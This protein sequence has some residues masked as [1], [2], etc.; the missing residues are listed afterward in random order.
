MRALAL[1]LALGVSLPAAAQDRNVSESPASVRGVDL[2]QSGLALYRLEATP[3]EGRVVLDVPARDGDDVLASLVVRDAGGVV[4]LRTATPNGEAGRSELFAG[5]VPAG[6][7]A[8]LEALRG[9]TVT[10]TSGGRT[11]I[12]QVVGTTSREVVQDGE[13]VVRDVVLMLTG[14]GT[15][16]V[17]ID[18]STAVVFGKDAGDALAAAVSRQPDGTR[19]FELELEGSA[20]GDVS[21]SYVAAAPAW[22]NAWR[23][24]L[25]E[26]R[27]QGWATVENVSGQDWEG[28]AL[29]LSTGAPAAFERDLLSLRRIGRERAPDLLG[30]RPD[31]EADRG[32]V[33][34]EKLARASAA[35]RALRERASDAMAETV[36]AAPAEPV[37]ETRGVAAT[38]YTVSDPVT[39]RA[40]ETASIPYL[41]VAVDPKVRALYRPAA[42]GDVVLAAQ[43]TADR[44]LA[45]G[46]VSVR[47][48]NGFAGDAPFTGME[49][50][51]TRLL[52]YAGLPNAVVATDRSRGE[53]RVDV[54]ASDG[55]VQA[56][57]KTR[58]ETT[59]RAELPEGADLF[60]VEVPRTG[61]EFVSANG[62]EEV[63]DAARR[64]TVPVAEG[65]G[66]VAIVEEQV[67][68][69]ALDREGEGLRRR[70]AAVSAGATID[71]ADREVLE[72]AAGVLTALDK[73]RTA[74]TRQDARY[75]QLL[76]EQE[77]LRANLEA[78]G[79]EGD[80]RTRYLER[81]EATETSIAQVLSR[82]EAARAAVAKLEAELAET[83]ARFE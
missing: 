83:I 63:R 80:A 27:M 3:S 21:L 58:F 31:V 42:T 41:D 29:T 18:G 13:K 9:R 32:F 8:L 30:G 39:L 59:Y 52:P 25:A 61:F 33:A 28:V 51:Q 26:G 46:M 10:L 7:A 79:G 75:D 44:P 70:L 71:R 15:E 49:A 2:G 53:I 82:Q 73:L 16:D 24:L 50:G 37:R 65:V 40:G 74:M 19:R 22:K 54:S 77:R 55:L 64:V 14:R 38:R 67:V 68:R 66:R 48:E 5:G 23:L 4:G 12:G 20:S 56:I 81:L 60:T 11:I 1:L 43:V 17:L 6:T 57:I 34:Q 62:E 35:P 76:R 36:A 72:A 78:V 45:P 69:E 47:D